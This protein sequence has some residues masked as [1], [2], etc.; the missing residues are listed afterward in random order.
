MTIWLFGAF[1]AMTKIG[2]L[3]NWLAILIA[4]SATIPF[5]WLK[6]N[7]PRAKA[8][9]VSISGRM[10]RINGHE[11]A[12][13]KILSACLVPGRTP[14]VRVVLCEG[15]AFTFDV[16]DVAEG[17][18][19]L[20]AL[21]FDAATK[22]MTFLAQSPSL[23]ACAPVLAAAPLLAVLVHPAA[24]VVALVLAIAAARPR[25]AVV[26]AD[27]VRLPRLFGDRFLPF[28]AIAEIVP[29]NGVSEL[30]L[31]DL[32][33]ESV[34]AFGDPNAFFERVREAHFAWQQGIAP[35]AQRPA[36][37]T[38]GNVAALVAPAGRPAPAWIT[39]VR[40][41]LGATPTYRA[42]PVTE[43]SLWRVAEDP[44]SPVAARAGA[45]AA[46][47]PVLDANGRARLRVVAG[48]SASRE[49]GTAFEK[50]AE[51]EVDDANLAEAAA[52]CAALR[53]E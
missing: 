39:E 51:E 21:G 3:E 4:S 29:G 37:D 22:N 35:G 2:R 43:D 15:D 10:L 6:S 45:A 52:A 32:R 16:A 50:A 42:S 1:V 26:G 5:F 18:A 27:G 28:S 48:A 17:L 23:W 24:L 34:R 36:G 41:L 30:V 11:T 31:D 12:R 47:A 19:L 44:S 38:D 49:L 14:R 7:P 13:S 9:S 8:W 40:A 46:L 20:H 53:T 25:T 33:R